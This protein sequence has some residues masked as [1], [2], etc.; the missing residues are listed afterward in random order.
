MYCKKCGTEQ[1]DGQK[2]CPKCGEPFIVAD[3]NSNKGSHEE[4]FKKAKDNIVEKA[5]ELSQ[6]SKD[7]FENKVQPQIKEKV[8]EFKKTDWDEK[9]NKAIKISK[10]FLSDKDKMR[11]ATI[12]IVII[13]VLWFFL[14]RGGFSA[15]WYWWLFAIALVVG[16][17]YKIKAKDETDALKKARWTLILAAVLGF[18]LVFQSPSGSSFGGVDTDIDY[19]ASN[20]EEE[21]ILMKMAEIRGE[22]KSILP[23]VEALYNAHQNYMLSGGRGSL[24]SSSPAWGKWQDCKEQIDNLWE[25]YIRLAQRLNDNEEIIEE[26]RESKRKMDKAFHDMFVPRY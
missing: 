19:N 7:F 18:I 8:E 5:G 16:A 13:S 10:D 12:G 2:F 11:K 9:K 17:F 3:D 25:E 22:I 26:A 1:K 15:S 20:S 4:G 14:F 24:Q 21:E 23:K 6:K